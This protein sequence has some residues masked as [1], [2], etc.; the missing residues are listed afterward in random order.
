MSHARPLLLLLLV[1]VLAEAH[2]RTHSRSAQ[3]LVASHNVVASCTCECCLAE[4]A[5]VANVRELSC[6][7]RGGRAAPQSAAGSGGCEALCAK[8]EGS[9]G[10]S[11]LALGKELDY[12]RF[13][14][15][16]CRPMSASADMLCSS[17]EEAEAAMVALAAERS[18]PAAAPA[19]APGVAPAGDA[20]SPAEAR[21]QA[22]E[23]AEALAQAAM[24]KAE[25]RA[26]EAKQSAALSRYAYEKLAASRETAADAAGQ[27]ALEQVIIDAR[28]DASE[29]AGIR[30]GWEAKAMKHAQRKALVAAAIYKNAKTKSLQV[31]D[32]WANNADDLERTG[33]QYEEFAL[34]KQLEEQK[35]EEM[36]SKKADD[37]DLQ[38]KF[39]AAQVASKNAL[40]T[41]TKYS[42]Q[43]HDAKLEAERIRGDSAW[44]DKA[45]AAAAAHAMYADLP[46]GVA[47]PLLPPL[48]P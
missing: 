31:A 25:R 41:A 26:R 14:S 5:K 7:P 36:L 32:A 29:A 18:A 20:A 48:P 38:A 4:K 45:A 21:S 11:F 9:L 42:E 16:A 34:T 22:E 35:L 8:P 30:A 39:L 15:V 24:R 10:E 2:L 40:A 13:C 17:K 37:T 33:K 19:A 6:L 43:G 46:E 12:S 44:Y 28:K 47:P 23:A 1:P 3:G 27:A